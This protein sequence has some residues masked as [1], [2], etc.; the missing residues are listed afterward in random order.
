VVR[1]DALD[2]L[3]WPHNLAKLDMGPYGEAEDDGPE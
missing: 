2:S 3:P 1:S